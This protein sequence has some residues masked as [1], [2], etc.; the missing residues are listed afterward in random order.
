MPRAAPAMT[1]RKG[2]LAPGAS[3]VGRGA[4]GAKVSARGVVRLAQRV[5][6]KEKW[7]SFEITSSYDGVSIRVHRVPPDTTTASRGPPAEQCDAQKA[8]RR[9]PKFTMGARS[10]ER[11]IIRYQRHGCLSRLGKHKM[12]KWKLALNFYRWCAI[13]RYLT[14]AS[15]TVDDDAMR[16]EAPPSLPEGGA[17]ASEGGSRKRAADSPTKAMALRE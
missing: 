7:Q 4:R 10:R 8:E 14:V 16:G 1:S 9:G 13:A 15:L 12:M 2:A 6:R 3:E 11:K 17:T 5:L